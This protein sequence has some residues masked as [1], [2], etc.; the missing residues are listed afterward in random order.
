MCVQKGIIQGNWFDIILGTTLKER[1]TKFPCYF[2]IRI[3]HH[4]HESAQLISRVPG[5]STQL[6]FV[7]RFGDERC[8]APARRNELYAQQSRNAYAYT[9]PVG[10][11]PPGWRCHFFLGIK[12]KRF[13]PPS[14]IE[15][16]EEVRR[17]KLFPLTHKIIAIHKTASGISRVIWILRHVTALTHSYSGDCSWPHSVI[18][19]SS[20]EY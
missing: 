3:S 17:V 13:S 7:F 14:W 20:K 4:F 8:H 15:F 16:S 19:F 1:Y 5:H 18:R 11:S 10:I 12:L 2:I 6:E 9:A